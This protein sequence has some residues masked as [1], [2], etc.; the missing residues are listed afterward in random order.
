MGKIFY[1]LTIN[2]RKSDFCQ[3]DINSLGHVGHGKTSPLSAKVQNILSY[4]ILYNV[5]MKD[6]WEWR[7]I[8]V[9]FVGISPKISSPLTDKL[10]KKFKFI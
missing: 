9:H 3:A 7:D 8:A 10:K 2:L 4:P 1:R 6:F 5:K